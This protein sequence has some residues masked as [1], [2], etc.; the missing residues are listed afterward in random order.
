MLAFLDLR[1]WDLI[2][3]LDGF[4][5]GR[6][7]NFVDRVIGLSSEFLV[8]GEVDDFCSVGDGLDVFFAQLTEEGVD[9]VL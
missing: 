1:S 7:Y 4:F 8:I 2:R 3:T 9:V 6:A 5:I